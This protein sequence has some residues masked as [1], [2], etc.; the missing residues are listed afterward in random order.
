[1]ILN[2]HNIIDLI[3]NYIL[4]NIRYYFIF[5]YLTLVIGFY[6]NENLIGGAVSDFSEFWRKSTEFANNFINTLE[7]YHLSG[8]RHSPV[9][10]S[11]Q[12]LFIKLNLDITLYRFL[13]LHLCL[14]LIFIFYRTLKI[15]FVNVKNSRILFFSCLIFLS[16]SFRSAALWP[17]SYSY[18]LIFFT[19]SI[20]VLFRGEKP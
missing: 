10:L 13:N 18:A 14:F 16:P 6:F 7:T 11:W 3:I 5:L 9:F 1:M 2:K 12:S 4:K 8:H 17:D 20:K 15:I 19:L